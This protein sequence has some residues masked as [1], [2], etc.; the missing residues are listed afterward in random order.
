MEQHEQAQKAE[1]QAKPAVDISKHM[2]L[3]NIL[4]YSFLW[5]QARL[6]IAALSLMLGGFPIALKIFGSSS[7][8]VGS[9]LSLA[10][11]I[12][13]LAAGY[14][15]YSW[16]KAGKKVFGGEEK[17]DCVA[18]WIA[19]IS[20]LHLG[21]AGLTG[22]NVGM[23]VV[24][25]GLLTLVMLAAGVLYLWSAWHLHTRYKANGEKLF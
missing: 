15:L 3:D 22:T 14:L 10:W 4:R 5:N 1:A 8:A 25:S 24:P 20:G 9:F 13:G 16:Y 2:K 18:F 23:T 17:K 12:S 21:W 11:I 6:V 7:S 19:I